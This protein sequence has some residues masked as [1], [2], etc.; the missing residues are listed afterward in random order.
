MHYELFNPLMSSMKWE[1]LYSSCSEETTKAYRIGHVTIAGE[2]GFKLGLDGIAGA[3]N[4][5]LLFSWN[6]KGYNFCMFS[7]YVQICK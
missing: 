1:F 6:C 7:V 2:P 4:H 3:L 5:P